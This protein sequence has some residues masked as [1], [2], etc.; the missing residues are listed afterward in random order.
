MSYHY[1]YLALGLLLMILSGFSL[2]RDRKKRVVCSKTVVAVISE[3]EQQRSARFDKTDPELRNIYFPTFRYSVD[4]KIYTHKSEYPFK[5]DN[6]PKVG[7]EVTIMYNPLDP[8]SIITPAESS[9]SNKRSVIV[10]F[11][12]IAFVIVTL[13]FMLQGK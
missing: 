6:K 10:F 13:S 1:E 8:T 7:E 4:G 5:Y 3:I 9:W 12:G 11:I 2:L